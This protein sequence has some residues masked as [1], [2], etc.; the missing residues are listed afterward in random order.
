MACLN[1]EVFRMCYHPDMF[2]PRPPVRTIGHCP[3]HDYICPTCGFGTGQLPRCK[4]VED[5][6][7]SEKKEEV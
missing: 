5:A 4:C 7:S 1:P 2:D 6:D 3:I